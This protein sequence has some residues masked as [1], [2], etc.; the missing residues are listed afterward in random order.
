MSPNR[1]RVSNVALSTSIRLV[2]VRT[3]IIS[4]TTY[5]I[6]FW[7]L[8]TFAVLSLLCAVFVV[9][10]YLSS[11]RMRHALQNHTILSL[12]LTNIILICT[13]IVWMLDGLRHSGR[14]SIATPNFCLA[15]WL[16]DFG[17]YS[18][19]T[20][21]LAWASVERHILIFH[22]KHLRTK[23]QKLFYH[24]LPPMILIVYLVGFYL[25]AIVIPP[26]NNEFHFNEIECGLEPC[27]ENLLFLGLWDKIVHNFL[28]TLIIACVNVALIYRIIAQKQRLR[29]PIQWRKHRRM[30]M[31]L[32]PIS[33]IYLFLNLPIVIV[34]LDQAIRD[35]YSELAQGIQLYIFFSTY[36][37]TLS[38]P[39]IVCYN[40][41]ALKKSRHTHVSPALSQL[42]RQNMFSRAAHVIA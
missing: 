19:Q 32:L 15:W 27:Y 42:P 7:F 13:D 30:S 2:D 28:P 40:H 4:E 17:L 16:I 31:Q 38:L 10:Q 20:V 8:L 12:V 14:V 5:A 11:R 39:F 23:R 34:Y 29:Q 9:Y 26:C 35:D 33:A 21:I 22:S 3:L 41:L 6:Q 37:L 24:Y 18:M 25:G 1:T 36:T